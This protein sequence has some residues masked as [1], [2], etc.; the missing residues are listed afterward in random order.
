MAFGA[1]AGTQSLYYVTYNNGGQLHKIRYTGTANRA[2]SAALTATPTAGK[3]PLT[4]S[5]NGSASLD[6]DGNAL[7]YQWS[8]R[9][10]QPEPDRFRADHFAHVHRG[11]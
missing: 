5:F 6:P 7:T 11:G 4:V 3:T 1:D 9:R 2:P 8:L 10:R